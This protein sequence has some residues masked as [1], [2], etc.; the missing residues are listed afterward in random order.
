MY[1]E[2]HSFYFDEQNENLNTFF[3]KTFKW[4]FL[5]LFITAITAIL[6]VALVP[7]DFFSNWTIL[8]LSLT[9]LILVII[10]SKKFSKVSSTAATIMYIVLTLVNG[11]FFSSIFY[12]YNIAQIGLS[13]AYASLVFAAMA[14]YGYKTKKDL[15]KL[16]PWLLIALLIC[17]I[18]LFINL[19]LNNTIF[20]ILISFAVIIVMCIVTAYNIHCMKHK[21]LQKLNNAHIYFAF[22]IYLDFLNIFLYILRL[23]GIKVKD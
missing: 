8:F 14:L 7:F 17:L 11:I 21:E 1:N 15:T 9:E 3:A 4:M 18:S 16:A 5:G 19:M 2:K 23:F 6:T 13:F 20:D 22:S 12:C 10:F